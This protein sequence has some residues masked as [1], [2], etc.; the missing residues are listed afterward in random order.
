MLITLNKSYYFR[1]KNSK[2]GSIKFITSG[3]NKK[4]L[5]F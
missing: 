4:I 2:Y 1:N 3:D 5:G